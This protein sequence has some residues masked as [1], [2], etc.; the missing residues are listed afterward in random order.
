MAISQ[1]WTRAG[2]LLVLAAACDGEAPVG[3]GQPPT[4]PPVVPPPPPQD[5]YDGYLYVSALDGDGATMLTRG[6]SPSWSPD[7]SEIAFSSRRAGG[8]QI[9][10]IG[11]D[12]SGVRRVVTA[13]A[14][15]DSV[16]EWSPLRGQ[17]LYLSRPGEGLARVSVVAPDGSGGALR[18]G[19]DDDARPA[20]WSPAGTHLSFAVNLNCPMG[21]CWAA[22]IGTRDGSVT[23]RREFWD[24]YH[25]SGGAWSPDSRRIAFTIVTDAFHGIYLLDGDAVVRQ[26]IPTG[27]F[28]ENPVWS[29]DGARIA[30]IRRAGWGPGGERLW[31]MNADGTG[32]QTDLAAAAAGA[33]I[34]WTPDGQQLLYDAPEGIGVV[35]RTG[36]P[37]RILLPGSRRPRISPQGTRL[38]FERSTPL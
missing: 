2:I 3:P 31:V 11:A 32:Q 5:V 13:T 18:S 20:R 21:P 6:T 33:E 7:G 36:G 15:R 29:P 8:L 27:A 9:H 22:M 23:R 24:A 14:G 26:Q 37:S 16:P 19:L 35:G 28:P 34:Q 25:M 10:A 17:I 12:G 1:R 30:F 4:F 38:L